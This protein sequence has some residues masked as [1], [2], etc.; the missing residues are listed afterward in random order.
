MGSYLFLARAQGS[1]GWTSSLLLRN[2][3]DA[4][5]SSTL[6]IVHAVFWH[7]KPY[8]TDDVIDNS[9]QKHPLLV[10]LVFGRLGED[11]LPRRALVKHGPQV[12]PPRLASQ[13]I[14]SRPQ[15]RFLVTLAH[16]LPHQSPL[17]LVHLPKRCP[18][19]TAQVQHHVLAP[20]AH[21]PEQCESTPT[22]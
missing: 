19:R 22:H 6:C 2:P 21:V 10:L 5:S 7:S 15:R 12:A 1:A 3:M 16:H 4:T 11:K 18:R 14:P 9:F 8:V 20:L 17:S 13:A